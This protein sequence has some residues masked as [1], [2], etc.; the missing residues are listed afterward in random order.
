MVTITLQE[1]EQDFE[2][3]IDRAGK[4]EEF[5]FEYDGKPMLLLPYK[6]YEDTLTEID[7]LVKIHREHNDGS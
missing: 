5:I 1:L 7:E 2:S 3:F 4:G 6:K